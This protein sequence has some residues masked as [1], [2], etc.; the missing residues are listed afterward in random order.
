[1]NIED[2]LER[3]EAE[4][5]EALEALERMEAAASSLA[6]GASEAELLASLREGHTF[7]STVLRRHNDDE[8]QALFSVLGARLPTGLLTA[9]HAALRDFEAELLEALEDRNARTAVSATLSIVQLTRAHIEQENTV[10]FP[11]ARRVL[12]PAGLAEVSRR[13]EENF[14]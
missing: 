14:P 2:P 8:E 13:L 6:S 1:M 10:F 11:A 12:G 5:E 7:L 9:H 3:F 4:H